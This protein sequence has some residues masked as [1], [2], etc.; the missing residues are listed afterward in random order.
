MKR[1]SHSYQIILGIAFLLAL[2]TLH[3]ST[4]Q[5]ADFDAFSVTENIPKSPE[6]GNLG[7]YGDIVANPY[8]GK[9]NISV[10]IYAINFEGLQI[11]IQLSYD[12]GGVRVASEASWVGLNWSTS[13][14]FGISRNIKALDDLRITLGYIY[15]SYSVDDS[16]STPIVDYNDVRTI[17]NSFSPTSGPSQQI[18]MQPDIFD[19]SLFGMNYKFRL[20]KKGSSNI[21]DT[22]VYNNPN[23]RITFDLTDLSFT[24]VDEKGFIYEFKTKDYSTT[25][26]TIGPGSTNKEAVL[27]NIIGDNNKANETLI[28]SWYLD[29]ITSPVVNT[30]TAPNRGVLEFDY[31]EGAHF[32]FPSYSGTARVRDDNTVVASSSNDGSVAVESTIFSASTTIVETNYLSKISG[33]FGEVNFIL[34]DRE[35]LLSG[36]RINEYIFPDAAGTPAMTFTTSNGQYRECHG[37]TSCG[38][39]NTRVAKRLDRIEVKNVNNDPVVTADLT[40][41]YY[42]S[43]EGTAVDKERYIRLKLDQVLVNDQ[44]YFFD[45]EQPNALGAKDTDDADFWGFYNGAGNVNNNVPSIGRFVT[46]HILVN[47]VTHIG[48]TFFNYQGANRGSNFNFGKLGLL[49]KIVYPTGGHTELC[50]ESHEALVEVAQP[51]IVT[52]DF[53]FVS[54]DRYRW[55]NMTD[56]ANYKFTYQYLKKA[57]TP[58]YDYFD[59]EY[60]GGQTGNG[61]LI[62]YGQTFTVTSPSVIRA[63]G[64]LITQANPNS[65]FDNTPAKVIQ[66]VNNPNQETTIF[67][68]GDWPKT[69]GTGAAIRKD[70]VVI[71]GPGTYK[72]TNSSLLSQPGV[73]VVTI[74]EEIDG[75]SSTSPYTLFD[76]GGDLSDVVERFEIGGARVSSISNYD[77]NQDF[78]SRR[79]YEYQDPNIS[80]SNVSSSGVLMDELIFFSKIYGFES[81]SPLYADASPLQLTSSSPLS[82]NASAQGSHIGYTIVTEKQLDRNDVELGR[83]ERTYFNKPNEYFLDSYCR[84]FR[85]GQCSPPTEYTSCISNTVLLGMDPKMDYAFCNGNVEFEMVYDTNDNIVRSTENKYDNLTGNLDSKYFASFMHAHVTLG[86]VKLGPCGPQFGSDH[87]TYKPYLSP[88]SYGLKAV[89]KESTITDTFNSDIATTQTNVYNPDTHHVVESKIIDSSGDEQITKQFY[90]YDTEVSGEA[91]I[92]DL[93]TENRI[94]FPVKTEIYEQSDLLSTQIIK[95]EKDATTSN[96]TQPVSVE[97]VKGIPDTNNNPFETRITYEKYSP[98]GKILQFR[99]EDGIATVLIWGYNQQHV[100]AKIENATY[101]DVEALNHFPQDFDLQGGGLS[102]DQVNS[103]RNNLTD[104]MVTTYTYDPLVGVTS[105]TDP[106]GYT[107]NYVYDSNNRLKE[108]R[109]ANNERVSDYKYEFV[110][111]QQN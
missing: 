64:L 89:L 17:H 44:K 97:V 94:S 33:D 32:T 77:A 49:T 78:I 35:D 105:I 110:D 87:T 22:H 54:L 68:V 21:V 10:P 1:V 69:A 27:T 95:Y 81:Y 20:K 102:T 58:T 12:T 66:N 30:T 99:R 56:E 7:Q 53:N 29:K 39:A 14:H 42:N 65:N 86:D 46:S 84:D 55:T 63:S 83:I 91:H 106:R 98:Q 28:T 26:Y 100:V 101:A 62:N 74:S 41:S 3:D 5:E 19:V 45:Y 71:I 96:I 82:T 73:P 50:Y 75:D 72:I 109:D 57:K 2:C 37:T 40:F 11:P 80:N 70:K 67:T 34:G 51:Y 31:T 24:I 48:Q 88:L 79:A 38:G 92:S 107:F 9:A 8:N 85:P 16:G 108:V 93:I 15:N 47:G 36:H 13:T 59:N 90:P 61:T 60:T 25:F 23:V 6:A 43:D 4:A 18:D 103:L 104:A 52:H 111:I 76:G